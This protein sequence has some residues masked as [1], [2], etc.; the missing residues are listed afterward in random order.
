MVRS[1]ISGIHSV[2]SRKKAELKRWL[3]RRWW[4]SICLLLGQCGLSEKCT[5]HVLT[6]TIHHKAPDCAIPAATEGLESGVLQTRQI[7]GPKWYTCHCRPFRESLI[8]D[9]FALPGLCFKTLSTFFCRFHY[10]CHIAAYFALRVGVRRHERKQCRFLSQ[11]QSRG[12][13][14]NSGEAPA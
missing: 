10:Q 14:K 12:G 8:V 7:E 13:T 4:S 3:E 11:K 2:A 9:L 6:M 1:C 5:Q